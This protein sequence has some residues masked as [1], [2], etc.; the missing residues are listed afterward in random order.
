MLPQ[1]S[2]KP[3]AIV[4]FEER[5]RKSVS[6]VFRLWLENSETICA[7]PTSNGV[8]KLRAHTP[9]EPSWQRFQCRLLKFSGNIFQKNFNVN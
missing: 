8:Q 3:F 6:V 9:P 1:Q 4:E 2:Q 5:G 7:W